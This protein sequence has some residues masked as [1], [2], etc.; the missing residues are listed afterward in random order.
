MEEKVGAALKECL[1]RRVSFVHTVIH[2]TA[3]GYSE[4]VSDLVLYELS[5]STAKRRFLVP[6]L[7]FHLLVIWVSV[8][9]EHDAD[10]SLFSCACVR[11]GG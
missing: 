11:S 4:L 1:R 3:A 10:R 2:T 7:R 5:S 6:G 8:D 9:L